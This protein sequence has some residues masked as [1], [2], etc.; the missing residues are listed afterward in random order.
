MDALI[1][2]FG[3]IF[4]FGHG[5]VHD[6][7]GLIWL[8]DGLAPGPDYRLYLNKTKITSKQ[9]FLDVKNQAL[10]IAPEKV[11][12]NVLVDML[13]SVSVDDNDSMIIWC[14][15]F[16]AFITSAHLS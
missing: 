9:V 8:D 6:K 4:S 12:K 11:L 5:K 14:E 1:V 10:Q 13:N 15:R 16:S 7:G 2:L 3:S